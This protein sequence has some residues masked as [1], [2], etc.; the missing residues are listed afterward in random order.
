MAI[1]I[2]NFKAL[3]QNAAQ[4]NLWNQFFSERAIHATRF[5]NAY[6]HGKT[7]SAFP[8]PMRSYDMHVLIGGSAPWQYINALFKKTT[9]VP[10]TDTDLYLFSYSP[11]GQQ[12]LNYWRSIIANLIFMSLHQKDPT[13]LSEEERKKHMT[14][15]KTFAQI[16]V[17]GNDFSITETWETYSNFNVL[18]DSQGNIIYDPA[19]PQKHASDFKRFLFNDEIISYGLEGLLADAR[20]YIAVYGETAQVDNKNIAMHKLAYVL[21]SYVKPLALG[22]TFSAETSEFLY[23]LL[24]DNKNKVLLDKIKKR[25][26]FH[27]NHCFLEGE[28]SVDA[29]ISAVQRKCDITDY[30]AL[31][32]SQQEALNRAKHDLDET[33]NDIQRLRHLSAQYE[34]SAAKTIYEKSNQN[35]LI[36]DEL[37]KSK[38]LLAVKDIKINE[39]KLSLEDKD[40]EIEVLNNKIVYQEKEINSLRKGIK[41][42]S[43][44]DAERARKNAT[45]IKKVNNELSETKLMLEIEIKK[46]GEKENIIDKLTSQIEEKDKMIKF[47]NKELSFSIEESPCNYFSSPEKSVSGSSGSSEPIEI[48]MKEMNKKNRKKKN[49]KNQPDHIYIS[50]R[51]LGYVIQKYQGNEPIGE[52][53]V[54]D[55]F[56]LMSKKSFGDYHLDGDLAKNNQVEFY[57]RFLDGLHAIHDVEITDDAFFKFML[58]LPWELH[59]K[60]NTT[61]VREYLNRFSLEERA[62]HAFLISNRVVKAMS[63]TQRKMMLDAY[64]KVIKKLYAST[65]PD[66]FIFSDNVLSMNTSIQ[67]IVDSYIKLSVQEKSDDVSREQWESHYFLVSKNRVL[68]DFAK[69]IVKRNYA[70]N[71]N[72]V[73]GQKFDMFDNIATQKNYER[74][75]MIAELI[76]QEPSSTAKTVSFY[77]YAE[78]KNKPVNRTIKKPDGYD[79]WLS[80]AFGSNGKAAHPM[81]LL[82]KINLKLEVPKSLIDLLTLHFDSIDYY[83]SPVN[84][85]KMTPK[86]IPCDHT[87][88]ADLTSLLSLKFIVKLCEQMRVETK[89]SGPH[90]IRSRGWIL[91]ECQNARIN[92]SNNNPMNSQLSDEEINTALILI[93][94]R[95]N[96][97]FAMGL[98][99]GNLLKVLVSEVLYT[100]VGQ[101]MASEVASSNKCPHIP[102]TASNNNAT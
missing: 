19:F 28:A 72:D 41:T 79:T 5:L 20:A 58:S 75:K 7:N 81:I 36:S 69:C 24:S 23:S 97:K 87:F 65:V 55:N 59:F 51:L 44:K 26:I 62:V 18:M 32:F 94:R 33:K 68:T 3:C 46:N 66:N 60:G 11:Q 39:L 74:E 48:E 50:E 15:G 38:D 22:K 67:K 9:I 73:S 57:S 98:P 71:N 101:R 82:K 2:N 102:G 61:S 37:E 42:F 6:I 1:N 100:L 29:H 80:E 35:V 40:S 63:D 77:S 64:K 92:L 84:G 47:L 93:L 4:E 56:F 70:L 52:N 13:S 27:Y 25:M 76:R 43:E 95:Y 21:K 78:I 14:L 54:D 86:K 83:L 45:E 10:G 53:A 91:Q 96:D 89:P 8:P 31:Y 30:K 90:Y 16:R 17:E 88:Y 12:A 85:S 34:Q 99:Q 49:K